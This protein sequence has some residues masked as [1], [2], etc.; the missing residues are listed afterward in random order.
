MTLA[1]NFA[2]ST[3]GVV[4]TGCQLHRSQITTGIND[5]STKNWEQYQT[6]DTLKVHKIE[7]FFCF[8]F[9]ICIITLLVM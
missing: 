1:A 3:T 6:A 2:T 9:E 8:D 4:D 7:I 5:T